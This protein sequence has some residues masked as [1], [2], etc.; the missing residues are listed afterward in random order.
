MTAILNI[1]SKVLLLKGRHRQSPLIKLKETCG[2]L[3]DLCTKEYFNSD[4]QIFFLESV[5]QSKS[6]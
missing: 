6:F 4:L 5:P 1:M 2:V 3:L